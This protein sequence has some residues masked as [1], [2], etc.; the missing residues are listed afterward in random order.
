M[1]VCGVTEEEIKRPNAA[2]A[3]GSSV[4]QSSQDSAI[5]LSTTDGSSASA[6]PWPSPVHSTRKTEEDG[7]GIYLGKL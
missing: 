1:A 5:H 6:S 7:E 3:S 4:G 2:E